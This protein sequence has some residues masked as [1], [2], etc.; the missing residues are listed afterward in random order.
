[1]TERVWIEL[2]E[3]SREFV[4]YIIMVLKTQ[5]LH[6]AERKLAKNRS[7]FSRILLLVNILIKRWL[8]LNNGF[9]FHKDYVNVNLLN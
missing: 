1:M 7:L 8:F 4:Q 2:I 5:L 6:E 9:F 3:S